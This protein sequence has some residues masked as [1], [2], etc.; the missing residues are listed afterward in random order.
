MDGSTSV[1]DLEAD[2]LDGR[3]PSKTRRY[4][5]ARKP[6]PLAGNPNYLRPVASKGYKPYDLPSPTPPAIAIT[7][8]E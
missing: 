7:E 2:P 3:C 8:T 1:P 5:P 6:L 4:T